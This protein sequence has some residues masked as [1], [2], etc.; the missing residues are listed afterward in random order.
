VRHDI[1]SQLGLRNPG[2]FVHSFHRP[3]LRYAVRG[4]DDAQRELFLLAACRSYEGSMIVY[5]PT[6]QDVM[7]TAQLLNGRGIPSV[8]YHGKMDN[9]ERR[10]NQEEWMA[11]TRR[12]MVGTL[13]FG[14]GINKPDV[15]AVI[16]LSLPKSLEQY[17]QEAGRAGRD[18][19]PADCVLLW[20][21]RD[22]GLLAYF[23][24]QIDDAAEKQRAWRRY[25]V[26]RNYAESD[27]CRHRQICLHFGE[28]PK[29]ERCEACDV[30]GTEPEWL[31]DPIASL[32][33]RKRRRAMIE[34]QPLNEEARE[35]LR[36]WRKALASK[37]K[38]PP[39]TILHDATIDELC[40]IMPADLDDLLD[41]KGIGK[42]KVQRHGERILALLQGEE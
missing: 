11:G 35:R 13:A 34:A 9:D 4:V 33:A 36:A 24:D 30:C 25:H 31:S 26:I 19:Q 27:A 1:V 22:I 40:R 18:G 38:V 28:T 23:I 16:H 2:K 6:I 42:A 29:W 3:N 41:V 10:A 37:I 21:S 15:R 14:L 12:V 17:Y 7:D 5:A 32:P 20:R 8:P 39:Y